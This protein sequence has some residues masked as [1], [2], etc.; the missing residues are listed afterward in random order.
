MEKKPQKTTVK[1]VPKSKSYMVERVIID[2]PNTQI[3]G[4]SLYWLGTG[5]SI[6]SPNSQDQSQWIRFLK[7]L[8]KIYSQAVEGQEQGRIQGGARP[9]RPV[10]LKLEKIRFFG[11]KSWFFNP[12][13]T[14]EGVWC[15]APLSTIFQQWRSV[16]LMEETGVPGENHWSAASHLQAL[17][18]HNFV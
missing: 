7:I 12:G 8:L 10:P 17:L 14:P 16:I 11:V 3:H 15:L 6:K 18:P 9:P 1:T 2:T 5:A 4:H 13:S